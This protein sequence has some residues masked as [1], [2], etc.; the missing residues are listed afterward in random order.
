M[1]NKEKVKN[2]LNK[3]NEIVIYRNVINN[4]LIRKAIKIFQ[5]LLKE[6]PSIELIYA[7]Y[8]SFYKDITECAFKKR[9]YKNIWP[10]FLAEEI[11]YDENPFSRISEKYGFDAVSDLMIKAVEKE[12]G[13]LKEFCSI[14]IAESINNLLNT[15]LP[16][17]ERYV[18]GSFFKSKISFT[19]IVN[20]SHTLKGLWELKEDKFAEYLS[21]YYHSNGCGIFGKY[22]AFRWVTE[23]GSGQLKG[24][25]NVDPITFEDL[26]GYEEEHKIVIENTKALLKGFPAN[27]VLL[28]GDKGTGKSSTIKALLNEFYKEGLRLIE[29]NKND[30]KDLSY[31]IDII[32]D[33]G[34]KFILFFDDLSFD[35]SEV[36]YKELKSVLEGGVEVL[37]LN[38]VIYATSNRRHIV[39][40]NIEDNELH[41]TDA[42]EEKLSLSDRFGITVT[43]VSPSQEEYLKIVKGLA[44]KHNIEI[45]WNLLKEKALQ[46]AIWH[47]GRS[48]RSAKQFIDHLRYELS[49]NTV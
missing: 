15:E 44:Q 14:N 39:T 17:F 45:E 37:P 5:E 48:P 13:S 43:F 46:W 33:R 27:N 20:T 7:E 42:R 35:E 12:I 34:M 24:I 19:E 9:I 4:S 28:Y 11:A 38:V 1:D 36:E 40:E 49:K 8:S 16:D 30:V 10:T 47:N 22:K 41:N 21:D 29:I 2:I 3:L 23:N 6:K 32:K 18:D 26:I 31:I 25:E